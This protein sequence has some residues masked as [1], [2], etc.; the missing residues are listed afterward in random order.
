MRC[1]TKYLASSHCWR[2]AVHVQSIRPYVYVCLQELTALIQYIK[3]N[4]RLVLHT[5]CFLGWV[6]MTLRL[7]DTMLACSNDADWFSIK[8]SKDGLHWNGRCW[9]I[10]ELLRYEFEFEFE[11]CNVSPRV[12]GAEDGN[13]YHHLLRAL[14]MHHQCN[15]VPATYPV[16]APEIQ[17]PELDGK[18]GDGL[19]T[20][21]N[22]AATTM[23]ATPSCRK[24][25]AVHL[26][27]C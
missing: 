18:T 26:P 22:G 23:I 1:A 25:L 14:L 8:S 21:C 7:M 5:E 9:Y 15:Q 19:S 2:A 20:A 27:P 3:Y 17:I 10:H 16:T 12:C 6:T 11:V 4:K 13:A 24:S